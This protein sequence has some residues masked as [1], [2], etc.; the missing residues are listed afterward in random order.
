MLLE[1]TD[2]QTWAE[3]IG[4]M[5]LFLVNVITDSFYETVYAESVPALMEL[6]ARWTPVVQGA[7]IGKVAGELDDKGVIPSMSRR[8]GA[9]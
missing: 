8:R 4:P 7:A 1:L 3:G 9:K 5:P 6:L 2:L